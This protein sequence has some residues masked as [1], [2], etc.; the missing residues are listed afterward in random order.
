MVGPDCIIHEF[1][2]VTLHTLKNLAVGSLD[3]LCRYL[4]IAVEFLGV[5]NSAQ[6]N[7]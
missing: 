7:E 4:N 2:K 5:G 3:S 6:K 1:I